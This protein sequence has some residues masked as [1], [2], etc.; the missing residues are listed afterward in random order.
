MLW[1]FLSVTV[2]AFYTPLYCLDLLNMIT[3][4]L[5]QNR[6]PGG[7]NTCHPKVWADLKC[8]NFMQ[9]Q[10]P[11]IDNFVHFKIK[12]EIIISWP[13]THRTL[14][15][16]WMSV[17][18]FASAIIFSASLCL[19]HWMQLY[20]INC[21]FFPYSVIEDF[22]KLYIV[23]L[24]GRLWHEWATFNQPLI[25]FKVLSPNILVT[26]VTY[27]LPRE[28]LCFR[29][30]IRLLWSSNQYCSES[31]AFMHFCSYYNFNL[32]HYQQEKPSA[33]DCCCCSHPKLNGYQ[34]SV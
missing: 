17:I 29:K 34:C 22:F 23:E 16:H 31:T 20:N 26:S 3:A 30:Y 4:T 8:V 11:S 14:C 9:V 32:S 18:L 13:L 7:L 2:T 33:R 19:N 25:F 27:S 5:D 15:I 12:T 6:P 24:I 21:I 28:R 1:S 10:D